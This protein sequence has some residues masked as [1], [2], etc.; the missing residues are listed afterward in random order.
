MEQDPEDAYYANSKLCATDESIMKKILHYAST[1]NNVGK[2]RTEVLDRAGT[3]MS[4]DG[5]ASSPMVDFG[6]N[7]KMHSSLI[8]PNFVS[9]GRA[10]DDLI[11]CEDQSER[12]L[13]ETRPR[14]RPRTGHISPFPIRTPKGGLT[15]SLEQ[16]ASSNLRSGDRAIQSKLAYEWKNIYRSLMQ[17]ACERE[18]DKRKGDVTI[19]E[20]NKSC[21]RH[22][23]NFT[24]EELNNVRK[25]FGYG[26]EHGDDF[27]DFERLSH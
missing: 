5:R 3:E 17:L 11:T 18:T 9:K 1:R 4:G 20:F 13:G 12:S 25:I 27:V 24:R 21:L 15:V 7:G 10:R 8:D 6:P 26:V 14:M 19:S 23:V 22:N 2:M 16:R